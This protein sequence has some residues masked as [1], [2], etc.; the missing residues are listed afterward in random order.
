MCLG[1]GGVMYEAAGVI[2]VSL[3]VYEVWVRS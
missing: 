1:L 3:G 2:G